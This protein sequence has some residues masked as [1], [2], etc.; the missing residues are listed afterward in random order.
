MICLLPLAPSSLLDGLH[1]EKQ[2]QANDREIINHVGN[3]Q[4]SVCKIIKMAAQVKN[5]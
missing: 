3:I 2:E 4:N 1:R 5:T